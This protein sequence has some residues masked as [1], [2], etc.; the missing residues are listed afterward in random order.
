MDPLDEFEAFARMM[1]AGGHDIDSIAALFGVERRRVAE[2]LRYGRVH[3]GIRAAARSKRITL[4][5]M[6][7]FASHPDHGTQCAVYEA[8]TGQHR[9]AWTIRDRLEKAGVRIGSP[10]GRYLEM[11]YHARAVP[12]RRIRSSR[13]PC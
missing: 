1:E 11:K 8:T 5:V 10:L 7:A 12:S 2:R 9:Q 4:D 13:T 6:K 3:P